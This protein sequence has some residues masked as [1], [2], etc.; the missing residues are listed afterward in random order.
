MYRTREGKLTPGH[1]CAGDA[2]RSQRS[3]D[4]IDCAGT[5]CG[6]ERALQAFVMVVD[7][8]GTAWRSGPCR[9]AM[10][11]ARIAWRYG[12]GLQA[13]EKSVIV[14]NLASFTQGGRPCYA[15]ANIHGAFSGPIR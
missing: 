1:V 6:P 3:G 5:G 10:A 9:W 7:M 2:E 4:A 14:A 13:K 12:A 15:E 11:T 8:Q